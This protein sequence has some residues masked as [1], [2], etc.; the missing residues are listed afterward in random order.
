MLLE[1]IVANVVVYLK[2]ETNIH[3]LFTELC[4]ALEPV[5]GPGA[6]PFPGRCP[7]PAVLAGLNAPSSDW[8]GWFIEN[9]ERRTENSGLRNEFLHQ[10]GK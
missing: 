9:Q 6:S 5:R 3:K 2:A 1:R 8:R 4:A 7:E 10:Q